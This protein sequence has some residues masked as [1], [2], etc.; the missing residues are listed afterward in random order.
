LAEDLLTRITR[1]IDERIE[2]L[3]PQIAEIPALESARRALGAAAAD[4]RGRARA[5]RRAATGRRAAG[6]AGK[7]APRGANREAILAVIA[8]RPDVSA[9]ELASK[10]GL[11]K[12]TLYTTLGTLTKQG[13]IEKRELGGVAGYH[14]K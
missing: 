14:L 6:R 10:T 9:A 12:P 8:E 11:A 1:E 5:S 7:R 2:E 13:T 4:G 3:R